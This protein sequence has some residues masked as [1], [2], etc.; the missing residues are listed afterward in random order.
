M[1]APGCRVWAQRHRV[2]HSTHGFDQVFERKFQLPGFWVAQGSRRESRKLL[3]VLFA[4]HP[5]MQLDFCMPAVSGF[6]W[7]PLCP[8]PA[9]A[10]T[11]PSGWAGSARLPWHSGL[12]AAPVCAGAQPWHEDAQQGFNPSPGH[13]LCSAPPGCLQMLLQHIVIKCHGINTQPCAIIAFTVAYNSSLA[14]HQL[15]RKQ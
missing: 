9:L 7:F 8:A 6:L 11:F 5:E 12:S 14:C 1:A 13:C 2:S 10:E 15:G 3:L 4:L